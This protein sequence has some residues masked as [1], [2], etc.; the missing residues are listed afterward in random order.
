M[1]NAGKNKRS[2]LTAEDTV[3]GTV[4]SVDSME[5][6]DFCNWL[7]EAVQLSAVL[8]FTYQPQS[9]VLFD[10]AKYV[11][12]DGK[13]RCMFRDHVYSPDFMVEFDPARQKDLAKE[14][15]VP[16][17]LLSA[18]VCSCWIDTKGEFNPNKRSFQ[19]DRKWVW[20]KFGV[21]VAEIVPKKFFAKFGVPL[22][23]FYSKKT[24]SRRK[25]FAGMKSIGQVLRPDGQTQ[26]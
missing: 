18:G 11:D 12:V 16:Q 9:F 5:E 22:K 17:C 20:Q 23:S 24:K 1:G 13:T 14:L 21:Y 6:S 8:D 19:T 4:L 10:G 2:Q 3:H 15:K 7:C 25:M 26:S